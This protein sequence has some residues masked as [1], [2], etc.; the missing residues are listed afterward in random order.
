MSRHLPVG[1][2][3]LAGRGG[4]AREHHLED[5]PLVLGEL[6]LAAVVVGNDDLVG[7]REVH[8]RTTTLATTQLDL[9]LFGHALDR[10]GKSPCCHGGIAINQQLG[11]QFPQVQQG[12][13]CML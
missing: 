11:K 9:A 5:A 12:Y 2:G 4:V 6:H 10:H 8:L 7:L 1:V 13:Y 3:L